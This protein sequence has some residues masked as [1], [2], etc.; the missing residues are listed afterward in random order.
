MI[1]NNKRGQTWSFDLIVAIILFIVVVT[2]FYTFLSGDKVGTKTDS[3][4]SDVKTIT[5]QLNCDIDNN[6]VCIIK[7]GKIDSNKVTELSGK[8]YDEIK[9][10]LGIT[11]DFCI[12]LKDSSG[13][14]IEMNNIS[15]IGNGDLLLTNS[16]GK[17][18]YC[19]EPINK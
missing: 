12:Y 9:V 11:G 6:G 3:L 14:L 10:E 4:E 7:K 5:T 16:S 17:A 13:A 2:L 1:K 19:G 8:D 18:T 15:G